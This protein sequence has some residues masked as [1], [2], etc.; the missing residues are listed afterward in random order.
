MARAQKQATPQ[1]AKESYPALVAKS[2]A[3]WARHQLQKITHT[4]ISVV[5]NEN[6]KEVGAA[7]EERGDARAAQGKDRKAAKLYAKAVEY[8]LPSETIMRGELL[9]KQAAELEKFE[10]FSEDFIRKLGSQETEFNS[11]FIKVADRHF[12]AAEARMK[13]ANSFFDMV[14]FD[15]KGMRDKAKVNI[16]AAISDFK[17]AEKLYAEHG[18]GR[19]FMADVAKERR[20]AAEAT[21]SGLP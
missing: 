17:M 13:V 2:Y 15:A 8:Y 7:Y 9:G 20:V 19:R 1:Q 11:F 3:Y 16:A 14:V 10:K 4:R 6:R 18:G 12:K 5:R 21:L